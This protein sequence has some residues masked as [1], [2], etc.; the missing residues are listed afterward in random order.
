M[1]AL[2]FAVPTR[3]LP[4]PMALATRPGPAAELITLS[5]AARLAGVH[6]DTVRAW[7]ARGE[8]A[9]VRETGR[10]ELRVRRGDLERLLEDRQRATRKGRRKRPAAVRILN[11]TSADPLRRLASE[12]SGAETLQPVFEEVL[13]NSQGLFHADRAGLWLWHPQREHPLELVA[14]RDFPDDIAQRVMAATGD[15]NLAGFEALRSETV[16]V[17]RDAADPRITEDMREG[18]AQHGIASLCFVPAI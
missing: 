4:S 5:E 1:T 16:L 6:R 13:D 15:S 9:A 12:L 2:N 14:R 17:Y 10:R 3:E 7:A 8:L 18:Y 11:P